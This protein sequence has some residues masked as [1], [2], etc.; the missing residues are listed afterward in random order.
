MILE[1]KN[2]CFSYNSRSILSDISFELEEHKV[3]TVLGPN[4]VGKATLL[5]C[6]M[7]FLH[8]KQGETFIAGQPLRTYKEKELWQVLSYVPQAKRSVFSYRVLDMVVMGLNAS[9]NFFK[10]P[11]QSQYDQAEELLNLLGC[12]EYM[13]LKIKK[14]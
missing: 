5:K 1:V 11:D 3:M 10:V 6:I 4:G 8:W 13:G 14:N 7:D 9:Q 2:G 12:Q